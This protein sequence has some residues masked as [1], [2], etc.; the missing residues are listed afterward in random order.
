MTDQ[1]WFNRRQKECQQMQL[2]VQE[3]TPE[4]ETRDFLPSLATEISFLLV[5]EFYRRWGKSFTGVG[6]RVLP[7]A[8]T[9]VS[10]VVEQEFHLLPE[11][12]FHLLRG[13]RVSP[14]AGTRVLPDAGT[15]DSLLSEQ[16]FHLLPEQKFHKL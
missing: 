2:T 13:A 9:R 1:P 12:E 10:P 4:A 5:Q 3:C 15:R 14:A 7:A 16:E 6:T 11:E 8:S